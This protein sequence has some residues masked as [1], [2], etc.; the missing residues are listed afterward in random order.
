MLIERD[1]A[2]ASF[3]IMRERLEQGLGG[4]ILLGGEAGIGKTSLMAACLEQHQQNYRWIW[5]GC[6]A[7]FTPRVLGPIY[8]IAG[9]LAC[10]IDL[11]LSQENGRARLFSALLLALQSSE[12]PVILVCEDFHWADHASLDLV[13]F[14]GRRVNFIKV[15]LVITFRDDEM[16]D[17]HPLRQVLGEL[18]HNFC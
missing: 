13:K 10:D 17:N 6:D 12:K 2:L 14:L 4:I 1:D 5:G 15:L 18:P 9:L 16:G 7:L 3:N 11:L 8:D